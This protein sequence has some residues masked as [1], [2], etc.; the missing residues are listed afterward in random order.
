MY[1]F[2]KCYK[3]LQYISRDLI[4]DIVNFDDVSGADTERGLRI[5]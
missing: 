1:A 2:R 5:E 4:Q 3:L